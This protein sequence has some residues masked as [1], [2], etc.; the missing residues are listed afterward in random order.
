MNEEE[1]IL[2]DSAAKGLEGANSGCGCTAGAKSCGKATEPKNKAA[3]LAQAHWGYVAEVLAQC[4]VSPEVM[5]AARFHYLTAFEHGYKHGAEDDGFMARVV[6]RASE[7]AKSGVMDA[8]R[9]RHDVPVGYMG[10]VS[11]ATGQRD[12]ARKAGKQ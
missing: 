2:Y 4:G 11:F 6:S 3:T 7:I 1:T 10:V 12:A 9:A 8:I 5:S